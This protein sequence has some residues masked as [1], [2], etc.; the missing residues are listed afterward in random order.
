MSVVVVLPVKRF[1]AIAGGVALGLLMMPIVVRTTEELLRL[2]PSGFSPS[3]LVMLLL[4][5]E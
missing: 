5:S 1:S 2:V 3:I 4:L